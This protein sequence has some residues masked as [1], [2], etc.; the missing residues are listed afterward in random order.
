MSTIIVGGL[1]I[2]TKLFVLMR[3]FREEQYFVG[4]CSIERVS[5]LTHKHFKMILKGNL[6]TLHV[7]KQRSNEDCSW[8][9][10]NFSRL[11]CG[12]L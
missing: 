6:S 11:A 3:R 5:V 9:G 7:L 1:G 4:A 2:D 8:M 10:S 12:S